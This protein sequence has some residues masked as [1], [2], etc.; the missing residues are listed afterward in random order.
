M[1][2]DLA[3][4]FEALA[5][6]SDDP[7]VR[8][9]HRPADTA[10]VVA[11][12]DARLPDARPDRLQ[13]RHALVPQ[14]G[15]PAL[16]RRPQRDLAALHGRGRADARNSNV[17]GPNNE[18][19]PSDALANGPQVENHAHLTPYP[20]TAAPG[21]ERECEAGN[22]RYAR[23][24]TVIGNVPGNQGTKTDGQTARRSA[25]SERR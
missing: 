24:K 9:G 2:E 17:F 19:L 5:D 15:Q 14:R 4:V 3:D 23:G 25:R 6:F 10:V 11:A 12:A 16:G 22:E 21:Q 1:N 8:A 7:M 20:N 13:L 18:G